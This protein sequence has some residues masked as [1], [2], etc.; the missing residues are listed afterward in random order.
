M[1]A[2]G[3]GEA[4]GTVGTGD[5]VAEVLAVEAMVGCD[6]FGACMDVGCAA[7]ATT[8]GLVLGVDVTPVGGGAETGMTV[9]SEGVAVLVHPQVS[10]ATHRQTTAYEA[11]RRT[12]R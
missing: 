12:A 3:V 2:S 4:S 1:L 9:G 11:G 6:V 8:A 7:V 10:A 5:G